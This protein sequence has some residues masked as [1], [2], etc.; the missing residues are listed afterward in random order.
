MPFFSEY[1]V[2]CKSAFV[3]CWQLVFV[4]PLRI[5]FIRVMG[6]QHVIAI[7]PTLIDA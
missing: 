6:P 7:V 3:E 2:E 5:L 4:A 1:I